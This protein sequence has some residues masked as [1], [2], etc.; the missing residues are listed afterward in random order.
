MEKKNA[1]AYKKFVLEAEEAL[2]L[3][4]N[5]KDALDK[6]ELR[7]LKWRY[8]TDNFEYLLI[9]AEDEIVD[10]SVNYEYDFEIIKTYLRSVYGDATR[11]YTVGSERPMQIVEGDFEVE[12]LLKLDKALKKAFVQITFFGQDPFGKDDDLKNYVK[13]LCGKYEESRYNSNLIEDE[14]DSNLP[15]PY[16]DF[17]L[18]K[19]ELNDSKMSYAEKFEYVNNRLFDFLQWQEQYDT[20]INF[21]S[22][23][24]DS[25]FETTNK[26]YPKFEKLCRLELERLEVLKDKV[27]AP[28]KPLPKAPVVVR[29]ASKRKTDIIKIISAMYD[30]RMFANAEGKPHTNKQALMEAFGEFFG[31]DFTTYSTL[32]SQAKDKSPDLFLKVFD[33]IKKSAKQYYEN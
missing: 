21:N 33:D 26:Y 3:I 28:P 25:N 9:A 11:H 24:E 16:F 12:F 32:L 27:E 19:Q 31:E 7:H 30:N 2:L 1:L 13:L 6:K 17:N 5:E 14:V 18:L 29:P 15:S 10:N 22:G 23:Y 8:N 4:M 20:F